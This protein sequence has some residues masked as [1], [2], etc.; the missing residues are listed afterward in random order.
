[1]S[2]RKPTGTKAPAR[3][4]SAEQTQRTLVRAA[5][6]LF[7]EKGF[8]GAS[9]RE[10]AA[11]A[12]ANIGSIAYHFGGKEGLRRACAE[13]IVSTVEQIA[14]SVLENRALGDGR[15]LDPDE[16]RALLSQVMET[17]AGF[18]LARPE[19]GE[20]VSFLLRE[21]QHPTAALDVIYD[22]VF[23]PVHERLCRVWAAATGEDAESERTRITVFTLIGQVVYFRIGGAAV[24]RRMGWREMGPGEAQAIADVVKDNLAATLEW[25]KDGLS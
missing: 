18:I 14:G 6:R 3:L 16:A 9:T 22:G 1:M 13:Y 17:V 4:S 11:A 7:G 2:T 15:G 25:R 10:I 23:L 5:L 12:G 8:E 21:L 24:K 20:I 19:A